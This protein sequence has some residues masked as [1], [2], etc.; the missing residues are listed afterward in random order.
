[1]AILWL[2]AYPKS[3]S[4]W[5]RAM[6]TNYLRD[7]DSPVSI[8]HLAGAMLHRR[9]LFDEYLGV[10]SS[11]LTDEEILR[12][13]PRLYELLARE[14]PHPWFVTVHDAFIRTA[15]GALFPASATAGAV[16]LVRNPLDIAVS[17]AHHLQRPI[18]RTVEL[19]NRREA[20]GTRV[21]R[22]IRPIFEDLGSFWSGFVTSWLESDLRVHVVRYEDMLADPVNALGAVVRFAGLEWDPVRLAR[23]VDHA[24]FD[25]LQAQEERDGFKG[26]HSP[27]PTFFRAGRAGDWRTALTPEQVR[28]LVDAHAPVMARL[29]YLDEA[30][31]FLAAADCARTPCAPPARPA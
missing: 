15:A 19:M 3:G 1:M 25:R 9:H 12:L 31:A 28:A 5:L 7:S 2:A 8:N 30:R 21:R 29:G 18:G 10:A 24:R 16:A 13:R 26:R 22:K 4:T 23:A 17:Y 27:A 14:L 20:A 6:L 11:D